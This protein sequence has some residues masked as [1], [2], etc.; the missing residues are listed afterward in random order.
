[1]EV[2]A[3]YPIRWLGFLALLFVISLPAHATLG[4][5]ATSVQADQARIQGSLR[6]V[7]SSAYTVHE[8]QA[9]S[10]T[11]VREY[12]SPAGKVFAVTWQ[13]PGLPDMKQVLGTYFDQY[14]QAAKVRRAR[15][16]PLY[17]QEPGLVIE[18]AG[19]SRAFFG[20]A[21]VPQMVPQGVQA[22]GLR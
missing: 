6:V 19:R 3:R 8:I 15:R 1:M 7:Q 11:V 4:A 18:M 20:R 2:T 22:D 16:S 9:T 5:N 10:G 14:A 17:V 21:Y 12:V 13:G